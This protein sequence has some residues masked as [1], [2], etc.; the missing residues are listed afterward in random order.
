MSVLTVDRRVRGSRARRRTLVVTALL[1]VLG[2][3]AW[4]IGAAPGMRTFAAVS[5]PTQS[6]MSVTVPFLGVLLV[7]GLDRPVRVATILPTI[8][9]AL[10]LALVVAAF[11]VLVC[12]VATAVAPSTASGGRWAGAGLV[13]I[14]SLL[15]QGVAQLAGT[16]LSLLLRRPVLACLATVVLPLGLWGLLGAVQAFRP[17]QAWITPYPSVQHLLSGEMSPTAWA[18]WLVILALWGVG[19]NALGIVRAVRR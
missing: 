1:G 5:G 15:V 2:T 17:V 9:R 19:L 6:L 12:G 14:G 8:A 7:S 3:V 4:T 13:V 16:G 11:G 18:Q 10:G